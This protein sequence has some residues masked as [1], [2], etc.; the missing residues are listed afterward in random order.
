MATVQQ[1]AAPS[2][3]QEDNSP[4]PDDATV[5]EAWNKIPDEYKADKPRLYAALSS[6]KFDVKEEDGK[7]V[8]TFNVMNEGQRKWVEEGVLKELET[9]L[10]RNTGSSKVILRVGVIPDEQVEE[11]PYMPDEQAIELINSN[12]EV[13]NLVKDFGLDTK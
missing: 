13:K 2:L 9:K 5:A 12:P 3:R 4:V 7:K 6:R 1:D 8:L 11:K 10:R